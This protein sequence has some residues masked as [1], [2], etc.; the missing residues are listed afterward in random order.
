MPVTE[1]N[2]DREAN[3]EQLASMV[4]LELLEPLAARASKE[5]KGRWGDTEILA[6]LACLE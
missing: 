2:Q 4:I 5:C 6:S 1:V 3:S